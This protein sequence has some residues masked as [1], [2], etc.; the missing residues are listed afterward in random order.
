MQFITTKSSMTVTAL[1]HQVFAIHGTKSTDATE[2]ALAALR[3]ANPHWGKLTK[4][5]AGT[6][7][8]VP[9]APGANASAPSTMAVVS[10]EVVAQLKQVLADAQAVMERS[11][12][13]ATQE[14]KTSVSLA[15]SRDLTALIKEAPEL[16]SRLAQ[17]PEQA[18][19]QLAQIKA[20]QTEQLQGLAQLGKDLDSLN[21]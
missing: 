15:K 2:Q 16:R 4:I 1:S 9:D 8:I 6:L 10:P 19:F 5:P 17:I 3:A 12:E 7:V 13:S 14:I 21:S 11:V 20:T 18:K